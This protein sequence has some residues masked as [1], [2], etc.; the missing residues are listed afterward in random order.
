LL[1]LGE[2]ASIRDHGE[3]IA[4]G[5]MQYLHCSNDAIL[6]AALN[7]VLKL[8]LKVGASA[9]LLSLAGNVVRRCETVLADG[10]IARDL[11]VVSCEV[12][13]ATTEQRFSALGVGLLNK[14][15]ETNHA[16]FAKFTASASDECRAIL[17]A[18][19]L[20]EH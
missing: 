3:A 7:L 19:H 14:I 15:S 1:T 2:R 20:V 10:D 4:A 6:M 16:A 8:A 5:F 9:A 13:R 11:L 12:Y 18:L 17:K